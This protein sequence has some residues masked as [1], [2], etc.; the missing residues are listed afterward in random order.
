MHDSSL[1]RFYPSQTLPKPAPPLLT[2]CGRKP[3]LLHAVFQAKGDESTIMNNIIAETRNNNDDDVL[4]PNDFYVLAHDIPPFTSVTDLYSTLRTDG[5]VPDNTMILQDNVEENVQSVHLCQYGDLV[6][7]TYNFGDY[8]THALW[9][10]KTE[11]A[12][13]IL[14]ESL[15]RDGLKLLNYNI[16]CF[17]RVSSNDMSNIRIV[18]RNQAI[19]KPSE[20]AKYWKQKC[21]TNEGLELYTNICTQNDAAL[22]IWIDKYM[23]PRTDGVTKI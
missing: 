21:P 16:F 6:T 22:C 13:N 1:T 4:R 15:Q 10:C 2:Y 7:S 14:K 18:P 8:P 17:I 12:F 5:F 11:Y 3:W 20:I 23:V 9:V 19:E